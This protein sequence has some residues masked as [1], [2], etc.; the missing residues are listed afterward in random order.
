MNEE[1][2]FQQTKPVYNV[3]RDNKGK[4]KVE[5]TKT[6]E[7]PKTINQ[8][9]DEIQNN[10]LDNREQVIKEMIEESYHTLSRLQIEIELFKKMY[11]LYNKEIY[12]KQMK[13]CQDNLQNIINRIRILKSL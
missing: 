12:L 5:P 9:N 2:Y 11:E 7:E 13:S 1:E 6:Q 3:S 4:T 8:L 10:A